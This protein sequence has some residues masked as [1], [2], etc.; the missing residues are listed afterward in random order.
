MSFFDKFDKTEGGYIFISHSHN[1]IEKVRQIRNGLEENGF[2]PLCFYLKCLEDATEIEDLIKREIDAR[3]WFVFV[4]SINSR[5]SDWVQLERNYINSTD[6][7]K[8]INVN[9]HSADAVKNVIAKILKNLRIYF[10]FSHKDVVIANRIIKKFREKDYLVFFDEGIT[11]GA[12][13]VEEIAN[14]IAE[15]SKEGC[16]IALITKNSIE[17]NYLLNE[18]YFALEL[19]GNI[20]PVVLG[21]VELSP[22]LKFTLSNR[23]MYF[24][25]ENP[26]DEDLD[27]L[28]N[29]IGYNI[30]N[31]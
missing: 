19:G 13:W 22:R 21:N 12:N 8:I 27:K 30:I 20:I 11:V 3:E 1:D 10:S 4:D 26:T 16:V 25:P 24:L 9:I 29:N 18:L 6:S 23:Q 2:E 7:K 15:A 5:K 14:Q 28:I 31:G 17:S